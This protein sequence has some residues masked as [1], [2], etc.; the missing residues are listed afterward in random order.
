MHVDIAGRIVPVSGRVATLVAWLVAHQGEI[1]PLE[2][3]KITSS[4]AGS[5][6]DIVFEAFHKGIKVERV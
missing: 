1:N 4:C 3:C 2:M 6:V 5:G